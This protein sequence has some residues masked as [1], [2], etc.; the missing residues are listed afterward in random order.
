MGIEKH[1]TDSG[2]YNGERWSLRWTSHVIDGALEHLVTLTG[3]GA[4]RVMYR[5]AS[6]NDAHAT[7]TCGAGE[8]LR[9]DPGAQAALRHLI[10][11]KQ[12]RQATEKET[13]PWQS[14][15]IL[16]TSLRARSATS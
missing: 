16:G 10:G 9:R 4:R 14:G 13:R 15:L 6:Y 3:E 11:T 7:F 2:V 5:G 1:G 12:Q 8:A